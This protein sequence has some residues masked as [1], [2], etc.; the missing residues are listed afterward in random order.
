MDSLP[1]ELIDTIIDNVPESSLP[2][3]SLIAK[4]WRRK[5]QQRALDVI[6]FSSE[7]EVHRWWKDIPQGPDG[8][9]S[10]VCSAR[11]VDI[12]RWN[13]PALFCHVV[14]N[15]TSLRELT[16]S[17][18]EIPEGLLG[19]ISRGEFGKEIET[20]YLWFPHCTL[21]AVAS[22]ILSL[23]DLQELGV[24]DGGV[25]SE[26]PFPTHS[27]TLRRR[28]L[29]LLQ[30]Y[31]NV[32]GILAKSQFITSYLSLD[33]HIRGAAQLLMF[34]SETVVELSICGMWF[35]QISRLN[36]NDSE[37]FLRYP[38]RSDPSSRSYTIITRPYYSCSRPL[39]GCPVTSSDE[40]PMFHWFSS[41]ADIRRSRIRLLGFRRSPPA[42]RSVG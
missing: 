9:T 2:C 37:Q 41:G 13:E 17:E 19:H 4:R 20:L 36:R 10:H 1:Q 24:D 40:H 31:E 16:I 15:L 32:N 29:D 34:S 6:A 21:A 30:L 25:T 35:F 22:M 3:C 27:V 38:R 5:S 42:G 12:P 23:P 39:Y 8:V 14:E 28:K 33:L 11:F 7:E 18:T 26:D